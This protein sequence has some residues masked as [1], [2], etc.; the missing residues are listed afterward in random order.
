MKRI[1]ALVIM[2]CL[3]FSLAGCGGSP[4]S[5]LKDDEKAAVEQSEKLA[6]DSGSDSEM[7]AETGGSIA[8]DSEKMGGMPQPE[9]VT[10]FLEQD[11]TETLGQN[12]AY[13]Y[14]VT[15]LTKE[16]CDEY[17]KLASDTFPRVMENTLSDTEGTFVAATEDL[18]REFHVR[19]IKGNVSYIQYVD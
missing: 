7:A 15:G 12:F 3:V 14:A 18:D 13:S 1:L 9:G 19:F 17:I 10:I 5:E 11:L 6:E 16:V 2:V 4:D 8:W